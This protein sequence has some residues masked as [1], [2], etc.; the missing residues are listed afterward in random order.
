MSNKNN[1]TDE[2]RSAPVELLVAVIEADNDYLNNPVEENK[3][4]VDLLANLIMVIESLPVP[5]GTDNNVISLDDLIT[6]STGYA[7]TETGTLQRDLNSIVKELYD[8]VSKNHE[9]QKFL[10][11]YAQNN[12]G[13]SFELSFSS[14]K[15]I[16]DVSERTEPN[17]NNQL[18]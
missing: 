18:D 3:V 12:L 7:I 6:A 9:A 10:R 8:E 16:V 2:S 11:S 15:L 4:R 14:D 13:W 1:S 17:K 5:N